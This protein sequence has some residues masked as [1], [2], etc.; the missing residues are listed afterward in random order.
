MSHLGYETQLKR[1][2]FSYFRNPPLINGCHKET[3]DFSTSQAIP[4]LL[5]LVDLLS[6]SQIY[7]IS[8]VVGFGGVF[9]ESLVL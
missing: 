2:Y 6:M 5:K 1:I 3:F 4:K 9:T 8:F 7:F